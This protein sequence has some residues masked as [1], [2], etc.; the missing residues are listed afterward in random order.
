MS[1]TRIASILLVSCCLL[2]VFVAFAIKSTKAPTDDTQNNE[3]VRFIPDSDGWTYNHRIKN[4][5]PYE[6]DFMLRHSNYNEKL[7]TGK[8]TT[9]LT[10]KQKT[11]GSPIMSI[12][13]TIQEEYASCNNLLLDRPELIDSIDC[14][15]LDPE[16]F[17]ARVS[18]SHTNSNYVLRTLAKMKFNSA[19]TG[20]K[21]RSDAILYPFRKDV[22]DE[23]FV[24]LKSTLGANKYKLDNVPT[25]EIEK[26]GYY[27]ELSTDSGK[28]SGEVYVALNVT[29]SATGDGILFKYPELLP[30][31]YNLI[32]LK[33]FECSRIGMDDFLFKLMDSEAPS[34]KMDF[35]LLQ[36][37]EFPYLTCYHNMTVSP[38]GIWNY[39]AV[40]EQ[41]LREDKTV[42]DSFDM[43]IM[44]E[45]SS[46]FF[47]FLN[48]ELDQE[49]EFEGGALVERMIL[50]QPP[51]FTAFVD[52]IWTRKLFRKKLEAFNAD[53]KRMPRAMVHPRKDLNFLKWSSEENPFFTVALNADGQEFSFEFKFRHGNS[54]AENNARNE[55]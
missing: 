9:K 1:S 48:F 23:E 26:F 36:Q 41:T 40:V 19:L 49:F 46:E 30:T 20:E 47:K 4:S 53:P 43:N 33:D 5:G 2:N 38:F 3:D 16:A 27:L 50:H 17:T 8:Y 44:I 31:N 10:I 6:I 45:S 18:G 12:K 15:Q 51:F 11:S 14:V 7:G 28:C 34:L 55:L 54:D 52:G 24:K 32:A 42:K 39:K 37:Q 25:S 35:I 22:V 13:G 21:S 29:G